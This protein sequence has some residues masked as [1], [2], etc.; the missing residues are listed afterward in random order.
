MVTSAHEA[1]HRIF[2]ERPEIL[3]PV[4]GLLGVPMP[5]K[6]IVEV[7]SGDATEIRPL[8]RRVDSVLRV[9]PSDGDPF[10]LA[11]EAQG[12]RDADKATSWSY[13]VAY[14]QAKYKLPVLLLVVCRDRPTATW[15]AGPFRCEARGWTALSTHPLVLGPDNVPVI[16]D[17]SVAA[18]DLGMAAFSA[19][20]HSGSRDAPAILEA[21]A[22]ALRATDMASAEYYGD[23]LEIGLADGEARQTWRDLMTFVTHFPGRG[24]LREEAYLEGKAEG[25]AAGRTVG[26][27]EGK[28]AGVAEGRIEGRA[29]GIAE[30]KAEGRQEGREEGKEEGRAK[31]QAVS[32]LRVL[33][34]RHVFVSEEVH[35]RITGCTD[36]DTLSHWLDRSLT[37]TEA[38]ALFTDAPEGTEPGR[39]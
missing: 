11:I 28:A 22:R 16:T 15:A 27:A 25:I 32:I 9:E 29:A 19:M 24:T 2:E 23:L 10:L 7:V 36:S 13:Y 39:H 37:V 4:F 17:A 34:R 14:L 6:A 31:G 12:R 3:S 38:E 5:E 35:E 1:S 18:R 26:E 30:G 20:T 21:L 33:G 8:E